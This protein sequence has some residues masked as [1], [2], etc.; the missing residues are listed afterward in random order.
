MY[1]LYLV[2]PCLLVSW[3][4]LQAQDPAADEKSTTPPAVVESVPPTPKGLTTFSPVL[5]LSVVF[6]GADDK[7]LVVSGTYLNQDGLVMTVLPGTKPVKSIQAHFDR[8]ELLDLGHP[9]E[10]T[11][12]GRDPL[13]RL[14]ILQTP[15]H[16]VRPFRL[17]ENKELKI[18]TQPEFI[19]RYHKDPERNELNQVVVSSINVKA[20]NEGSEIP[21]LC[22][23]YLM[24]NYRNQMDSFF[25]AHGLFYPSE[26]TPLNSGA[27]AGTAFSDQHHTIA[28]VVLASNPVDEEIQ[29]K[30][31]EVTARIDGQ[32]VTQFISLALTGGH[33]REIC[34]RLLTE[35]KLP[36]LP[37]L[38]PVVVPANNQELSA[39]SVQLQIEYDN[40]D[41]SSAIGVFI[42]SEE[43]VVPAEVTVRSRVIS[44]KQFDLDWPFTSNSVGTN[45]L[46]TWRRTTWPRTPASVHLNLEETPF[47]AA[48]TLFTIPPTA[49]NASASKQVKVVGVDQ[50]AKSAK[51]ERPRLI[52][53]DQD[54]QIGTPLYDA[55]GNFVA[56]VTAGRH[57]QTGNRWALPA[58]DLWV[59]LARGR[60]IDAE[61]ILGSEQM[62][63]HQSGKSVVHVIRANPVEIPYYMRRLKALVPELR[64]SSDMQS[65]SIFVVLEPEQ[66]SRL[67][68]VF[69]SIRSKL[70]TEMTRQKEI[71][72]ATN[73]EPEN[74]T[75]NTTANTP[76]PT[77]TLAPAATTVRL[78]DEEAIQQ[79]KLTTDQPVVTL[80]I[81]LDGV[82]KAIHQAGFFISSNGL[83]LTVITKQ[84]SIKQVAVLQHRE[85][86]AAVSEERFAAELLG[87]EKQTGLSLF[88][89]KVRCSSPLNL[90]SKLELEKLG[91]LTEWKTYLQ[92]QQTGIRVMLSCYRGQPVTVDDLVLKSPLIGKVFRSDERIRP[93]T[94]VPNGH[95]FVKGS[96]VY[97]IGYQSPAIN[98]QQG[99]R[100]GVPTLAG[101]DARVICNTLLSEAK[102]PVLPYP[103]QIPPVVE[104]VAESDKSR[105]ETVQLQIEHRNGDRR[106]V[107]GTVLDERGYVVT[108][109]QPATYF[110]KARARQMGILLDAELSDIAEDSVAMLKLMVPVKDGF[111]NIGLDAPVLHV[112]EPL[113]DHR[114]GQAGPP[115]SPAA[116]ITH[117]DATLE[118]LDR[119]Q[120]H[121]LMCDQ[122]LPTGTPLFHQTGAFIGICLAT[123]DVF[124]NTTFILPADQVWRRAGVTLNILV[125]QR[126]HEISASQRAGQQLVQT[127]LFHS[128]PGTAFDPDAEGRPA[129]VSL[130]PI[131]PELLNRI[132]LR[133]KA[134]FPELQFA[135]GKEIQS[136]VVVMEPQHS[137]NLLSAADYWIRRL[138][139][140]GQS[141]T[142]LKQA[143]VQV[144]EATKTGSRTA[145]M[146]R[147]KSDE[148]LVL[149][150]GVRKAKPKVKNVEQV[151]LDLV[152]RYQSSPLNQKEAV[153]NELLQLTTN[154]FDQRHRQRLSELKSLEARLTA[155]RTE[156]EK[157]RELREEIIRKRV[158]DLV[159]DE[160]LLKWETDEVGPP[161]SSP[162]RQ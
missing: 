135:L 123:P 85:E 98:D 14:A 162:V 24:V 154:Q 45:G 27:M 70:E 65:G 78:P 149:E 42:N 17:S 109:Y 54:L 51:V 110:E 116:T 124:Q 74:T 80:E 89:T 107:R 7:P 61:D 11:V 29:Q 73:T 113:F 68:W 28:A 83:L 58:D 13:T 23:L 133:V 37:A 112:G 125:S 91:E 67:M 46:G 22:E 62:R 130:P 9:P 82:D 153:R 156:I 118:T 148:G 160:T 106:A 90:T 18:G 36:L 71:A 111:V 120:T 38:Q 39:E 157:R 77:N 147:L 53:I 144:P 2:I 114:V 105:L 57:D 84:A 3:C 119:R 69:E 108:D 16:C 158:D 43:I 129:P 52:Q 40:G 115:G 145:S 99:E 75:A 128:S 10:I 132:F 141:G 96:L 79:A 59:S 50:S 86:G 131:S 122:A 35:A 47:R 151:V 49:A 95:V 88:K 31:S 63:L 8:P 155:L 4:L 159:S 102:L 81:H 93:I 143:A 136:L 66:D 146:T 87:R 32:P 134:A 126:L 92:T 56:L 101:D 25:R 94:S 100:D 60:G 44:C 104:D 140:E 137:P 41:R 5:P 34:N 138:Q 139:R 20:S 12:V 97:A 64:I 30:T 21:N 121:L 127:Y 6:E 55:A 152:R 76:A 48:D 26:K 117:L 1:R 72:A 150:T 33:A 15:F 19:A 161:A 103:D 142:N